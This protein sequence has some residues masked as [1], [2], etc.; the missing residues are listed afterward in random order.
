MLL[1]MIWVMAVVIHT[2]PGQGLDKA[3]EVCLVSFERLLSRGQEEGL[4]PRGRGGHWGWVGAAVGGGA[5][6]RW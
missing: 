5:G 3:E 6:R 1:L 4:G 2:V